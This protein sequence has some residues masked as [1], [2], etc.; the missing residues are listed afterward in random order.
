MEIVYSNERVENGFEYESSVIVVDKGK[1]ICRFSV[2]GY[3]DPDPVVAAANR[4][5]M[6]RERLAEWVKKS[7]YGKAA[8]AHPAMKVSLSVMV[9]DLEPKVAMPT[10]IE[11]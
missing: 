8:L 6:A 2:M 5:K 4:D 1:E 10:E 9:A 7:G 3:Q 11:G